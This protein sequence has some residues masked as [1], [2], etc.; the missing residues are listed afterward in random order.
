MISMDKS[1]KILIAAYG[2]LRRGYGNSRL[3]DRVDN[4]LGKGIT[5]EKYQMLAN[6]IPYVNKTPQSNITV[7]LWEITKDML[8]AVDRLEG[9]DPNDHDGSWYKRELIDVDLNGN[10]VKAWLYFNNSS[11]GSLVESGDF[12][13][14]TKKINYVD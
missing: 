14:Y 3:V 1:N 4:Y 6:F 11:F 13:D 8:P 7:D 10:V 12:E 9:Y 2:T 5:V